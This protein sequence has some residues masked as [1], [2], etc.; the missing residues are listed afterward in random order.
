MVI[1]MFTIIVTSASVR[2]N[3]INDSGSEEAWRNSSTEENTSFGQAEAD[4]GQNKLKEVSYH[5]VASQ[6]TLYSIAK[7]YG[8]SAAELAGYNKISVYESLQVGCIH[9]RGLPRG[10]GR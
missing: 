3:T 1:V 10:E 8:L 2:E 6:E 5:T 9:S 4:L 7:K